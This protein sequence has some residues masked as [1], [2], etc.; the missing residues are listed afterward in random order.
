MK[1]KALCRMSGGSGR[2]STTELASVSADGKAL[3][4]LVIF[5]GAAVQVRWTSNDAYPGTLYVTSKTG[6]MEESQF[7]QWFAKG[8]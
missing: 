2:E 4:P 6:W 3:P 5:K 8:K 7:F 1:G